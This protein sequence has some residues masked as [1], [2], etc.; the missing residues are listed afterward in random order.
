MSAPVNL[1]ASMDARLNGTSVICVTNFPSA[2]YSPRFSGMPSITVS[3][4]TRN[5][6][7]SS[8]MRHLHQRKAETLSRNAN[9][10]VAFAAVNIR[11]NGANR[12]AH[13]ARKPALRHVATE[14]RQ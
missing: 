11:S 3:S 6:V 5:T 14:P 1:A 13:S 8:S 2:M 10:T 9:V 12:S 4:G 7:G